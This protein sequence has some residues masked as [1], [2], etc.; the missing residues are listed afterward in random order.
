MTRK[1]ESPAGDGRAFE[2]L[3]G[4]RDT[5]KDRPNH[6]ETQ[7]APSAD[8]CVVQAIRV[9]LSERRRE[10]GDCVPVAACSIAT[11]ESA[12]SPVCKLARELL[13]LGVDART[14][15]SIWRGKTKCFHDVP[16]G[17]LAAL[18]VEEG[19]SGT[20][21]RRYKPYS[22]RAVASQTGESDD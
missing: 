17:R 21:F 22:S 9:E 19:G 13:H 2:C 16:V 10:R 1:Q 8:K 4:R 20:V 14:P 15:L 12:S 6:R 3:A 18:T 11:V 7:F 5:S